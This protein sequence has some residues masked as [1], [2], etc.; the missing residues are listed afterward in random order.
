MMFSCLNVKKLCLGGK[1]PSELGIL[2]LLPTGGLLERGVPT[3]VLH[4]IN[5][6]ST[7][8]CHLIDEESTGG[9]GFRQELP[10]HRREI[11]LK[12]GIPPGISS[13]FTLTQTGKI[14]IRRKSF[15]RYR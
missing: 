9:I 14:K 6:E 5:E 3:L 13:F 1:D 15:N 8:N 11:Y 2:E 7:G 4:G 10:A 12:N